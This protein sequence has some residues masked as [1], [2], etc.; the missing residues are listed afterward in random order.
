MRNR[1]GPAP[2]PARNARLAPVLAELWPYIWPSAR[3]DLRRRI[4]CALV[5]LVL[6]KLATIAVPYRLQMGDRRPR[7]DP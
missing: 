4:Y 7:A 2:I 5:L 6:A 3:P 1:G